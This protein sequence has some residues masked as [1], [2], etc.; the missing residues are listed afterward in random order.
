LCFGLLSLL[1]IQCQIGAISA[2]RND[3]KEGVAAGV[4]ES[5]SSIVTQLNAVSRLQSERFVNETNQVILGWQRSIDDD[6]FGPW[7]NTTT[8]SLNATLEQFYDKVENGKCP[9]EFRKM[10]AH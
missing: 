2:L 1:V 9:M 5:T 3:T 10:S 8:V 6:L 4:T 7:L